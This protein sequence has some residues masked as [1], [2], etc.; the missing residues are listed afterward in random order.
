MARA[1]GAR[2]LMAAAFETTYGTTPGT[3][4]LQ[5]PF[6]RSNLSGSA[7][8]LDDDVLG[9]G[10]DPLAPA[11][12]TE[13]I[14]GDITIP[15]EAEAIGVWLKGLFGAPET[16]GVGP[17]THVF[18]SGGW[19]LPSL[20]I[21]TGLPEVPSFA[22]AK[23]CKVDRITF[24]QQYQGWASATVSLIGQAET[25]A[26]TSAAGSPTEFDYDHFLQ[27]HGTL[28]RGGSALAEVVSG[29]FT[30]AN[31]LERVENVGNGGQ[32]A[33]ADATMAMLSGRLVCRF[34]DTTLLDQAI[35]GES[36]A[37]AFGYSKGASSLTFAV[38]RLFLAK[39]TRQVDGPRGVQATFDWKAA[40][41][42]DGGPMVTA[43]LINEVASY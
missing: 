35:N 1:Y 32:I 20:S 12:D 2:S 15:M 30:Y 22:M 26:T 6:I 14:G 29:E 33:G 7:P 5:V 4:F 25:L 31:N 19:T 37:F 16:T 43:T 27:R 23:G 39:P 28:T 40:Q 36:A 41:A 13:T 34:A 42:T 11:L 21:E 38:P 10:R 18:D 24:G 8:L 17:Y 9:Q 3:G